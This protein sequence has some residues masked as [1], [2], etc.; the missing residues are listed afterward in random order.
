M[1]LEDKF[2]TKRAKKMQIAKIYTGAK[3]GDKRE[4]AY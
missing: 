2:A 3:D 4:N 1:F